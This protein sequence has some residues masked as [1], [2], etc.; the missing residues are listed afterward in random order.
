M[1]KKIVLMRHEGA[2]GELAGLFPA[3]TLVVIDEDAKVALRLTSLT[4]D[5][6]L[7]IVQQLDGETLTRL[8]PSLDAQYP[9]LRDAAQGGVNPTGM[10]APL[11]PADASLEDHHSVPQ[12]EE[13]MH[14]PPPPPAT[15]PESADDVIKVAGA[16]ASGENPPLVPHDGTPLGQ[17]PILPSTPP[18]TSLPQQDVSPV[19]PASASVEPEPSAPGS[20]P[21]ARIG[22]ESMPKPDGND[23][24]EQAGATWPSASSFKTPDEQ[25]DGD[26][27]ESGAPAAGSLEETDSTAHTAESG[28]EDAQPT[29]GG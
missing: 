20:L 22:V 6:A 27:G 9:G 26:K 25:A 12:T 16:A 14:A 13:T 4:L 11:Q 19:V 8:A 17:Q 24:A 18:P 21:G 2:V 23:A 29:L 7:A 5:D 15:P 1:P 3:G 10:A 28:S